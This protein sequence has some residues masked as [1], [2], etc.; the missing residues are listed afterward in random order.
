[1][2]KLRFDSDGK[3]GIGYW[4]NRPRDAANLARFVGKQLE[5]PLNWQVINVDTDW[6]GGSTRPSWRSPATRRSSSP[7]SR[8]TSCATMSRPA[9]CSTSR[10]TA[11]RRVQQGRPRSLA[12]ELF[13]QVRVGHGPPHS[14]AVQTES[15]YK[16]PPRPGLKMV[17]QRVAH[18]AALVA[19]RHLQVLAAARRQAA[20][21]RVAVRRQPVRLRRRQARP[22]QAA[23]TRR[24]SRR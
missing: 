2:S 13:P 7:P 16:I 18:P 24:T 9:G 12:H 15:V 6:T 4:L 1:M 22:A 11:T 8:S 14:S 19:A 17:T 21:A 23:W 3:N 5:H 20:Q 10:P